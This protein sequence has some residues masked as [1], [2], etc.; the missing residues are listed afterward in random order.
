VLEL[1]VRFSVRSVSLT[2]FWK[3][4]KN[5][6]DLL[7]VILCILTLFPYAYIPHTHKLAIATLILR[8]TAQVVRLVFFLIR[9]RG[10][11]VAIRSIEDTSI[12][13][14]R[15][16]A[17]REDSFYNTHGKALRTDSW[18]FTLADDSGSD[19]T[20]VSYINP[21]KHKVTYFVF[22]SVILV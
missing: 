6:L 13:L 16:I 5:D 4:P 3:N 2:E 18:N 14:N 9:L 8:Y 10:Q 21:L 22:D 15:F 12:D 19:P 11:H 17:D 1:L 20:G 7:V